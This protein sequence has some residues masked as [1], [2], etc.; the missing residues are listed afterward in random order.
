MFL[1][2]TTRISELRT[3]DWQIIWL[4]LQDYQAVK[5]LA[6]ADQN[7]LDGINRCIK[8]FQEDICGLDRAFQTREIAAN[9]M[10]LKIDDLD[11]VHNEQ[12]SEV[13]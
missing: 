10:K 3:F 12:Q 1:N 11:K 5:E 2:S 9:Q 13:C 8:Q 6:N 4:T 7:R